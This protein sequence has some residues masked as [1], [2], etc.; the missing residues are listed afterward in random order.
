MAPIMEQLGR[1]VADKGLKVNAGKSKVMIGS[2]GGKMIANSGKWPGG[3]G[4]KANSIQC[5]VCIKWMHKRYSGVCNMF[6][7]QVLYK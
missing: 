7:V 3:K 1:C 6:W 4:V 2:S 5:T